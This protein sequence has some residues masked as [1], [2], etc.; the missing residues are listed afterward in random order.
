MIMTSLA[1]MLHSVNPTT[2]LRAASVTVVVPCV[3]IIVENVY[4]NIFK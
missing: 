1:Q 2:P 3:C 4:K